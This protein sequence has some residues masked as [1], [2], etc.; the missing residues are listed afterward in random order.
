MA[1]GDYTCVLALPLP[2]LLMTFNSATFAVFFVA[3]LVLYAAGRS[4]SAKKTVLLGGGLLF[5]G[6]FHPW[7]LCLIFF[8][9][10]VDWLCV[11]HMV[12]T[13]SS[14]NRKMALWIS[15]GSNLFVLCIFKYFDFFSTNVA[16]FLSLLGF[17]SDPIILG[18][19]LPIGISFYTFE[20]ISYSVDVYLGKFRPARSYFDL[21]SF[22]TFFPH[23]VAGPIVR[24]RDFLPQLESPREITGD[25]LVTGLRWI[26][27]G[28]FF[29]IGVADNLA[30]SVD[31]VFNAPKSA[32]FFEAWLGV[33]YFSFQ[34]FGDFAGYTLIARGLAKLLG[35]DL[36]NNFNYPYLARGFSDFWRRWHI[37]LSTWLRD[38][39][40]IP[41]GGNRD[42]QIRT[43]RNL[44]ITML[45]GGL[46]H[47]AAWT[48]VAWGAW[49]GFLLAVEH[50]WRGTHNH[51]PRTPSVVRDASAIALTFICVAIGWTFFRAAT[52][53]DALTLLTTML[54][55]GTG[56]VFPQKS[57]LKDGIWL[58]PMLVYFLSG[59]LHERRILLFIFPPPIKAAALA[60]LAFITIT[61]REASDA[62][63]YFQ[64]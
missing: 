38:Y 26:V 52:L 50:A 62:F 16:H 46:W 58:I 57:I 42:G 23:L 9:T 18:I 4:W 59:Y 8:S 32:S 27:L 36:C 33:I 17:T 40:Y 56:I 12:K 45:L 44:M 55:A 54:G 61:C 37:S 64:F 35:F 39:L 63:I 1:Q 43:Y 53:D 20:A 21:L 24:A 14:R 29:K 30:S 34:I 51:I 10:T 47:G 25:N 31:F 28:Y 49:H 22:I 15:V 19:L 48:Y 3:F 41:L 2:E 5:Y 6:W 11:G 7:Y 13:R 60:S